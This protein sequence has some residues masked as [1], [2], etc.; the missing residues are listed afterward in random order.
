MSYGVFR[1]RFEHRLYRGSV[2]LPTRTTGAQVIAVGQV[3]ET[4]TAQA[5]T[6]VKTKSVGQVTE[7]DT[8][9]AI[10][11]AAG[12]TASVGQVVETD[13]AQSIGKAKTKAIGQVTETDTAQ[14]INENKS[15]TVGQPAETDTAQA[16]AKR[17]TKAV[18]QSVETDIA[19]SIIRFLPGVIAVGQVTETD[20]AFPIIV[21]TAGVQPIGGAG[22]WGRR[23]AWPLPPPAFPLEDEEEKNTEILVLGK[24]KPI[25]HWTD[26]VAKRPYVTPHVTP[27]GLRYNPPLP[28]IDEPKA[29]PKP[30]P[31][32]APV[33]AA[34]IVDE[35]LEAFMQLKKMIRRRK[36]ER[37]IYELIVQGK[38]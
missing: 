7:I 27:R 14:A 28:E 1:R 37:I 25:P 34:D 10:T 6:R 4:D 8:A 17:K 31:V 16:I 23:K 38:L 21:V 3:V 2:W 32:A 19:Q 33:S 24:E 30:R 11:R 20:T 29:K 26:K 13:T 9:Q 35:D 15:R 18:G 22:R 5:I 12:I 36:E